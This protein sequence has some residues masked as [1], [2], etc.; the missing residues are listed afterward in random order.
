MSQKEIAFK[1]EELMN[2]ATMANSLQIT[3][4]TAFYYQETYSIRDFKWAFMLLGELT[5]DIQNE[6]KEL[7]DSA[8]DSVRKG[9]KNDV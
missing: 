8:F 4:F 1:I 6:L 5:E 2:K 7:T 9:K 3:L